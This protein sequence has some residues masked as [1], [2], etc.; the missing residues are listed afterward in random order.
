MLMRFDP[1]REF[2]RMTDQLWQ[3]PPLATPMPMDAIRRG[4]QVVVRLDVPGVDPESIDLTVERNVLTVTAERP[5]D[6]GEDDEV[7]TSERRFGTV[8]RQLFLGE[9]LDPDR[10]EAS[11]TH[12]VLEL[13]IPV[14]ETAKPRKV[15]VTSGAEHGTRELSATG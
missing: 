11:Y 1:F 2:D 7:I 3:R 15:P 8:S 9:T 12:G 14:A 4:H 5:L 10:V 6:R 13:R